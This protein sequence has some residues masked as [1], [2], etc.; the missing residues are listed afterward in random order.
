[1]ARTN[2]RGSQIADGANGVDLTVDV[3]GVLPIANGGTNASSASAALTS[4]GAAPALLTGYTSGSGTVASTDTVL[5]AIQKLNGNDALKLPINN[6]TATGTLATPALQ[7]TGGTLVA[8]KALISDGSG[9]A[10][11]Q[12]IPWESEIY[13]NSTPIVASYTGYSD[14]DGGVIV[15]AARGILLEQVV[16]RLSA[17]AAVIGGSGN[18]Q[19]Q[20]YLGSPTTQETTLIQTTQIAAGQHD[21]TVTFT[22]AQTCTVNTVLRAKITSG[23]ATLPSKS[24]VQW[25]GSLL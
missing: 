24:S 10:T 23:T 14:N 7:V 5:Q 3:T 22:S 21:V 15:G 20:W 18:F 17:P 1:M 19:I 2:I 25:R 4:L 12:V 6:P 13:L 16:W 8:G 11:W 9:N